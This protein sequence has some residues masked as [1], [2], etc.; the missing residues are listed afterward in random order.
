MSFWTSRASRASEHARRAAALVAFLLPSLAL[1]QTGTLSGTVVDGDFGGGLPGASVLVVEQGT[2]AATEVDGNYR[3][4]RLPVGTYT[5]RYSFV[6]YATQVVNNVQIEAGAPTQINVTLTTDALLEEVV[7]EAEEI[8]A[9][10]SEVGLLRVRAR[11]AQV[12]DA[13][14]AE[15]ISQSGASDAG[16]AMERV[17]G[18]SVQGGQY[19]FVRGLGDRYANTQLNGAVLP[20]ADPDRRAVQFDLFPAGFLENIV[21]LKTFTPDKPGSFSGG[22]VDITTRSFPDAFTS[23]F[24]VSTG[25]ST[26]AV[27]GDAIVIDPVQGSSLFRFGAGDLAV[28]GLL[29][30]TPRDQFIRPTTRLDGPG[31]PGTG[32]LVRQDAA[33]SQR[34]DDL[35]N[36]LTPMVAPTQGTVPFTG[37]VS[38]SIG[39][40]VP[41]GR[42]AVGYIV[43]LTADQGVSAYD[44]GTLARLDLTGRDATTGQVAVDTTQ[45]RT[46]QRATQSAQVGG[47]ANLAVQLG[48]YNEVALNTLFSHIT[49]SQARTLAGVDNV[50]SAGTPVTDIVTGYTERT[51]GSAQLRGEHALPALG[52]LEVDWRANL[53]RT[54]LDQPDLRQAAIRS[55]VSVDEDGN[56]TTSYALVGTPP[57]PQRYFRDLEETLGSGAL[58]LSLP[59][60][61]FGNGAQLKVGG[62]VERT[63]RAYGER[64]FFYELDRGVALG[65]TDG[66]ALAT[67][68]GPDNVGVIGTRTNSAGEVTQYEFGHYLIDATR[69]QNQYDGTFDV[70][71]GYG[72]VEV[73]LGRLR[74]IA[75]ARYEGSRLLVASQALATADTPADSVVTVDGT[76]FLG[77]D[78]SYNDVLPSLNLVYGLSDA[79]NLRAAA[80]RTLAR[81][82]FREIA[83]VTTYDFTSDGALQGNPALERTL[84][85]NLD[86]RWEW[87][88]QPGGILA[89]SAYYKRLDNPIER[90]IT[91]PENG[92]TSYANV[93]A[94]DVFGAEFEARQRL[95]TFGLGGVLGERLSLGAN[96]SL[97]QSSISITG[98]ELAARRELDPS[99]PDTRDLQ[100][101]S[102]YLLNANL[103]YDDPLRGTSAGVFF[104]VAGPRLSRVGNPLPDVYERPAPQLDLTASQQVFG[105]FTLK[106]SIK[107]VLGS[108]YLEAYDVS[109]F[110]LGG[111]SEVAPFLRYARGTQ[112]SLGISVNP[113]F[114]VGAPASIPAPGSSASPIGT[115]T[116]SGD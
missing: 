16:D 4:D 36:A 93:D 102:P 29:A 51:L 14:S 37:S 91:D 68:L 110:D 109:G 90:I 94:A 98:R 44:G 27:P 40:R 12:S 71:A 96:L 9:T 18:A 30:D 112:F 23:S 65:G 45:F 53:S 62:L 61:A 86:L 114:G 46:D 64:F 97:T 79:M 6:G 42:N 75:G 55:N 82:T 99:A 34:L 67:Y 115:G 77:T 11:A 73:G 43:G 76:A 49:E 50:L 13:I 48:S 70:A 5:V 59:F 20:T 28:P 1:A 69:D 101:Q 10:N 72:M 85:T 8:I 80:T 107:N 26:E 24:S 104:N 38:L 100:G 3:I 74:L 25:F 60:R 47:I 21:T 39:D 54:Q 2:G 111:P 95:G 32:P 19:V 105:A 89:A 106:G 31:G 103:S 83:P 113:S 81:P 88:N 56:E 57:G 92:A 41:V 116:A 35:S 22:L 66:D 87:F 63:D 58:D 33:A 17:T 108:D 52:N 7:V 15:T 84:I 78:R